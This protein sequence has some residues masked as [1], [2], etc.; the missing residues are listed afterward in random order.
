MVQRISSG[1]RRSARDSAVLL[2]TAA[3]A[4]AAPAR[5]ASVVGSIQ[6]G[7]TTA[8]GTAATLS[9]TTCAVSA[10]GDLVLFMS[11]V[12]KLVAG[13]SNL[14]DGL[15]LKNLASTGITRVTTQ[16]SGVQLTCLGTTMTPDGRVVAFNSGQAAMAPRSMRKLSARPLSRSSDE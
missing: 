4:T 16:R 1:L 6:P 10:G 13:D 15:C 11:G 7:S 3:A 8:G 2:A 14:V 12:S 5:T 9:C